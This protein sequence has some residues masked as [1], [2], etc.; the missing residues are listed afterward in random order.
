M[1]SGMSQ[2]KALCDTA[3]V[4]AN[5]IVYWAEG[6]KEEMKKQSIE[7]HA[8]RMPVEDDGRRRSKY[9]DSYTTDDK[10]TIT[11]ERGQ[12]RR[13]LD[14]MAVQVSRLRRFEEKR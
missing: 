3:L 2:R 14:E 5:H 8:K 13:L 12:I 10:E 11:F 9:F 4:T 7:R 6:L 1:V